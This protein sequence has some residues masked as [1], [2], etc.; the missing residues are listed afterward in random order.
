MFVSQNKE[1]NDCQNISQRW[2]IKLKICRFLKVLGLFFPSTSKLS[3]FKFPLFDEKLYL[4]FFMSETRVE[5]L[6]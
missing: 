3:D 5:T 1:V 6:F 2:I 4:N